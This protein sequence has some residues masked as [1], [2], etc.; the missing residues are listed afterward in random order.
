M[1]TRVFT[2]GKIG[3][4]LVGMHNHPTHKLKKQLIYK[5]KTK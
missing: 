5:K 3:W 2:L 4:G 1:V